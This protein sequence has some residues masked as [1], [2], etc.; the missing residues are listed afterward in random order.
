MVLYIVFGTVVGNF[1]WDIREHS[2]TVASHG[3][4]GYPGP[5]FRIRHLA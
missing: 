2:V 5:E 4:H 3:V 1:F